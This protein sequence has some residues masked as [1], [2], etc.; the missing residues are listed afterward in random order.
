MQAFAYFPSVIYRE[1]YPELVEQT[2]QASEK[3]FQF[4]MQQ[5]EGADNFPVIQTGAMQNDPEMKFLTDCFQTTAVNI[6]REQG[7]A[8]DHYDFYVSA[9]WGHELKK[10][11][12]NEAHIHA[13]AQICGF[14]FFETHEDGAY[15]LFQD[16]RQGKSMVELQSELSSEVKIATTTINFQNAIPGTFL[17]CNAWLPHQI[18]CGPSEKPSR[19][20]HFILSHREKLQ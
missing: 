3:H 4:A 9:M 20:I 18:V 16:P 11:G 10:Y 15:P 19:F 5:I 13:N 2:K 7:Y 12:R 6:L 14:Y 17:F 8:V 1:E